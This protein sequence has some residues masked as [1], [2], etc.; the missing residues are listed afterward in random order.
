M[1]RFEKYATTLF[2]VLAAM[3]MTACRANLGN[4]FDLW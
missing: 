2:L 1:K 3:S 4:L